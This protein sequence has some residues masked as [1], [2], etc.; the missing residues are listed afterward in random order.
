MTIDDFNDV[1]FEIFGTDYTI[2][3][4]DSLDNDERKDEALYGDFSSSKKLIRISKNVQDTAQSESE[5]YRTLLHEVVH[6]IFDTGQYNSCFS[7]EPLVEWISRCIY[8]L[9]KQNIISKDYAR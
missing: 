3:V 5:L 2:K 9:L 1:T 4:V 7:D 6:A 8:S